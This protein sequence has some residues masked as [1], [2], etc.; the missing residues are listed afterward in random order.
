M[1]TNTGSGSNS[2]VRILLVVIGRPA[3]AVSEPKKIAYGTNSKY[4][5]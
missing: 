4:C 5:S 3:S 2:F 1:F